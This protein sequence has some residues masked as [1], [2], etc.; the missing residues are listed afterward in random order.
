MPVENT[1]GLHAAIAG[2]TY[3]EIESGH[4]VLFEQPAEFVKHVKDFIEG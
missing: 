3:A 4:V 2:S 1:R